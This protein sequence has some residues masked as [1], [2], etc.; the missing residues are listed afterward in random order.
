MNQ[1]LRKTIEYEKINAHILDPQDRPGFHLTPPVGWMSDP[2]GFSRYQGKYHLFYQYWPFESRWGNPYW[3]HAVSSDLLRWERLPAALAPDQEYDRDGCFS[4]TALQEDAENADAG[5]QILMYT[6]NVWDPDDPSGRGLQTQ[7]IAV[8][9]GLVYQKY[10]GNPVIGTEDLPP[11]A[12]PYEFRDPRLL[13]Q[14]DGTFRA[15]LA[16]RRKSGGAQI[17]QYIS[18]DGLQWK[19]DRCLIEASPATAHLGWMWEC[20]DLFLLDG[21]EIL[22][23]SAIDASETDEYPGGK[24]CFCMIGET[25]SD[26]R[27]RPERDHPLDSGFD[28][29]AGQTVLA[30]DGRRILIGWMQNPDTANSRGIELPINGQMSLPRELRLEGGRILQQPVRELKQL[31]EGP[32]IRR[33]VKAADESVSIPGIKGRSADLKMSLKPAEGGYSRFGMRFAE[34]EGCYTEFSY[35]PGTSEA[36]ID[37][38]RSGPGS[39]GMVV[40]RTKVRDRGGA[41][42]LQVILDRYSAEIFIN[43][44]EQVLSV[45][46]YTGR[47]ADDITFCVNGTAILDI[48]GYRIKEN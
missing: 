22:V 43:D 2:N 9:D 24:T 3:G 31:R 14:E 25:G 18:R 40:R 11:G 6:G 32:E 20:P 41:L 16:G 23:A 4:G 21:R 30:P 17:L 39:G 26:G 19:Y 35:D 45:V 44:G 48:A 36:V 8:G 46:I 42:D 47:E 37:R 12:D 28:F 27:F 7:C 15:L 29:Y 38:S 13:R 1:L 33:T 10:S 34:G 5:R